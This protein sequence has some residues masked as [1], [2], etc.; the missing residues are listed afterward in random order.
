[1]AS[2]SSHLF[3]AGDIDYINNLN[4]VR[5]DVSG[6]VTE[7]NAKGTMS[8]QNANAVDITG[9]SAIGLSNVTT[10][11]AAVGGLLTSGPHNLSLP[12][13]A[14]TWVKLLTTGSVSESVIVGQFT[15]S[16]AE[17]T[18]KIQVHTKYHV[19]SN[20]SGIIVE[21]SGYASNLKEI[22]VTGTDGGSKSIY[23]LLDTSGTLCTLNWNSVDCKGGVSIYNQIETPSGSYTTLVVP[24]GNNVY[25]SNF[26]LNVFN[27]NVGIGTSSPSQ[28]LHITGSM[29]FEN[30]QYI[31]SKVSAGTVTRVFGINGSND[32]QVGSIDQAIN[33]LIFSTPSE[34]MRIVH[35]TGNVLVGTSTDNGSDKLQV[36]GGI[37]SS[38]NIT[39][40][41]NLLTYG[42]VA[43]VGSSGVTQ[44]TSKSTAVTVDDSKGYIIMDSSTLAGGD[45][46]TFTM[47][48]SEISPSNCVIVNIGASVNGENYR[49]WSHSVQS[50]VCKITLENATEGSLSEPVIISFVVIG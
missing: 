28:Q 36:N 16:T 4:L 47:N 22:R 17:E 1:M 37:S 6:L 42:K 26:G 48:N 15:T 13:T 31:Y 45:R 8:T 5:T 24:T 32:V 50:G 41:G 2:V 29:Q 23:I 14:A 27:N 44:T 19:S 35:S 34:R 9:G 25:I 46:V 43:Y 21:R 49:V 40:N 39:A 11:S 30:N 33:A 18:F 12:T 20:P 3:A 10:T 7:A 38:A